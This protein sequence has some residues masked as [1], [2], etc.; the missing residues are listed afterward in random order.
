MH[1]T[2]VQAKEEKLQKL[3]LVSHYRKNHSLPE[4]AA[5]TRSWRAVAQQALQD[6]SERLQVRGQEVAMAD[7]LRHLGIEQ[8]LVR[9]DAEL[10]DFWPSD[11]G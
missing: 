1:S 2:E 3:K 8:A 5:L 9:Y 4:L 10:E 11:E 6:L 7:L